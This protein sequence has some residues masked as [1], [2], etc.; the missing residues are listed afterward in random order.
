MMCGS[1]KAPATLKL[2]VGGKMMDY[3]SMGTLKIVKARAPKR[4]LHACAG[5]RDSLE[6]CGTMYGTLGKIEEVK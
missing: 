4:T 2:T 1:C 3:L 5:H 6:K